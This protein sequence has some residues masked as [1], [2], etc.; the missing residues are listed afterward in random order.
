MLS[1]VNLNSYLHKH[2][3]NMSI[4]SNNGLLLTL[5][6]C[7][8]EENIKEEKQRKSGINQII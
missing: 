3:K 1:P 4:N 8:P 6:N 2:K 5:G 7:E